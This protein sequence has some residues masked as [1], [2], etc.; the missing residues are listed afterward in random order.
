MV[1]WWCAIICDHVRLLA[2]MVAMRVFKFYKKGR[3]EM[4][5]LN[6]NLI[7]ERHELFI[8]ISIGEVIAASLASEAPSADDT[9]HRR[10]LLS[11]DTDYAPN[12]YGLVSL[13][14]LLAA[15]IKIT[16]FDVAEHPAPSGTSNNVFRKH[17]MS[18]SP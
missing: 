12:K 14:V 3:A 9:G 17:A 8:I 11:E 2:P 18:A 4:I 13:V 15:L 7:V 5:P 10:D 6:V 16:Y 1:F